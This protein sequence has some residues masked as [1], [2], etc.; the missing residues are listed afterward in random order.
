MVRL[1]NSFQ[2]SLWASPFL[3]NQLIF[4]EAG[5]SQGLEEEMNEGTEKGV[6]STISR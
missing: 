1:M 4:G 5:R 3:I 6:L 2:K